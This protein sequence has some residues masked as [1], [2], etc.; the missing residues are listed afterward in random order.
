MLG[1]VGDDMIQLV[2]QD[3]AHGPAE[4]NISSRLIPTASSGLDSTA[5]IVAG[6]IAER[7]HRTIH[8]MGP[9]E[10]ARHQKRRR[11]VHVTTAHQLNHD[12][13]AADRLSWNTDSPTQGNA[14]LF[15]DVSRLA[16]HFAYGYLGVSPFRQHYGSHWSWRLGSQKG[17]GTENRRAKKRAMRTTYVV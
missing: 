8:L 14:G 6:E 3:P 5:K 2:C 9:A 10:R 1:R 4:Q 16:T 15:Q 7:E 17:G 13:C 12:Q 11:S